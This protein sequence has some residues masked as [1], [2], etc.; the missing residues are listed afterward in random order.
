MSELA[1]LIGVVAA[2]RLLDLPRRSFYRQQADPPPS[3]PA[4]ERTPHPRALS[5]QE[6]AEVRATLNSERFADRSPRTIYATLLDEGVYL[7]HWRTMY[8]LLAAD[9]ATRERRAIRRH[10]LYS[11]PEL[12]ATAPRQVWSWDIT[13]LRGPYAGVWYS[14]Y[15]VLDIFSRAIVGWLVAEREDALL[16]EQLLADAC[17]REGIGWQELVIHAD[18]G[19]PMTSK[20]VSELLVDLGVSRSHSRPRV[21]NDNPYSEAQFKTLKYGASYPERFASLDEARVWVRA[22]VSWYNSEHRHSG[23]G[24][25]TPLAVHQGQAPALLAGRQ[26]VLDLSYASHPERFVRG[27]PMPAGVPSSVWINAPQPAT[28]AL[29]LVTTPAP[30]PLAAPG[31]RVSAAQR[32]LDAGPPSGDPQPL[33]VAQP[34]PLFVP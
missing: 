5:D 10:P 8:R 4:R 26:E 34:E 22:F 21:S 9:A 17:A 7:C 1:P 23:I 13:K 24:L 3:R 25:L 6:Q 28:E 31:S 14:L 15:V 30:V 33:L 27:R 12:L 32:P 2:C 19:A 20:T 11:R 29:A 16:A 18:R